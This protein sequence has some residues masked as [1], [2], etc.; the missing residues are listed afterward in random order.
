MVERKLPLAGVRVLDFST[1]LPGPLATLLLAEAGAEVI[2]IERP[3]TGDEL[4]LYPP[5]TES[6]NPTFALLNRGKTSIEVD[7]RDPVS[8]E[9]LLKLVESASILVEQFRPGVMRR[10]GFDFE[11]L[12]KVNP[13]LIYCSITGYGQTGPRASVAAHD[14][15]Y[16]AEAGLL[17]LASGHRGAPPVP[18][19]LV[20][21][22]GG[23]TFPAVIN[24]LLALRQVER[25]GEGC[26][27]DISMTDNL[28]CWQS[29]ALAQGEATHVW[30][31]PGREPLTG[32]SP[33]YQIYET[34]DKRFLA[35]APLE[36]RFWNNF[37]DAIDLPEKWLDDISDPEGAIDAIASIIASQTV[38]HWERQFSGKDVCCSIVSTLQEARRSP[39]FAERGIFDRRVVFGKHDIAALPVPIVSE[40]QRPERT[41]PYPQRPGSIDS[42]LDS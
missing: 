12:K 10:F 20:A 34:R 30:P 38:A 18:P 36:Q 41:L 14:L 25:T 2:K 9:K 13:R 31:R 33:R 23:G 29:W 8:K 42:L 26:W 21:D 27:L 19:T 15:N 24:I 22:I 17:S 1:L 6:G 3:G 37:C 40:F 7:L 39:Y 16:I 35:A 5:F 32:G 28:F 11:A 4:R